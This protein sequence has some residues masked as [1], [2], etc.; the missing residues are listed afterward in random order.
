M[1][2]SDEE[3]KNTIDDFISNKDN[4]KILKHSGF[5]GDCG[6]GL[7]T[8]DGD[9]APRV[10]FVTVNLPTKEKYRLNKSINYKWGLYKPSEQH[11]ILKRYV[12]FL[13]READQYEIYFEY[14]TDVNL[15]LHAI[16]WYH[17]CSKSLAIDTKRFFGTTKFHHS[18]DVREAY[19]LDNLRK[20]KYLTDKKEKAYQT[21]PFSPIIKK[22]IDDLI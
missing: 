18:V 6:L 14:T 12:H 7:S 16:V 3:T 20:I 19:D 9:N 11:I 10:Y 4:I 2:N 17:G 1:E 15:H 21:S 13:D 22:S 8:P 5:S